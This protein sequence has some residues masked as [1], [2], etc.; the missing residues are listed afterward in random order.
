MTPEN[1]R[2]L[3]DRLSAYLDDELSDAERAEVEMYLASSEDARR[4]LAELRRTTELLRSLPRGKAPAD[5][6]ELLTAQ[7]E[8]NELLGDISAPPS[9][10]RSPVPNLGRWL[11]SAA[12]I[13]LTVSAGYLTYSYLQKDATTSPSPTGPMAAREERSRTEPP[14]AERRERSRTAARPVE[15]EAKQAE[16][17]RS[18]ESE[19]ARGV[20]ARTKV[21]TEAPAGRPPATEKGSIS[22]VTRIEDRVTLREQ[23]A[24]APALARAGGYGGYAGGPQPAAAKAAAHDAPADIGIKG[25]LRS[26]P[27]DVEIRLVYTDAVSREAAAAR[28]SAIL[29]S[30]ESDDVKKNAE[31]WSLAGQR[32][33]D[34]GH[35]LNA[36][37]DHSPG[38]LGKERQGSETHFAFAGSAE[39]V[40]S[41]FAQIQREV[42]KPAGMTVSADGYVTFGESGTAGVGDDE[43]FR[44]QSVPPSPLARPGDIS[45]L[46]QADAVEPVPSMRTRERAG[47]AEAELRASA[48]QPARPAS[49]RRVDAGEA[50]AM[51]EAA[52]TD[53]AKLGCAARAAGVT[54]EYETEEAAMQTPE[55]RPA[56]SAPAGRSQPRRAVPV[57][58]EGT[59]TSERATS[60]PAPEDEG[61]LMADQVGQA[62]TTR[63][64]E[65]MGQPSPPAVPAPIRVRLRLVGPSPPRANQPMGPTQV[66]AQDSQPA[67]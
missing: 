47:G 50:P 57:P 33:R 26:R 17:D 61:Q 36:A 67:P 43:T 60:R 22:E 64:W 55:T 56:A 66:P 46:R 31:A 11:A 13:A 2:N 19:L 25:A 3:D 39:M 30:Y 12:A 10:V 53:H 59:A 38:R 54:Y 20:A 63:E 65:S 62:V 40:E 29:D 41:V 6:V 16:A 5:M 24:S 45:A 23:P 48:T 27:R 34:D 42:P 44:Y 51:V 37:M 28:I 9:R 52:R 32:L 21:A 15:P 8:R 49:P 1:A 4:T 14:G 7:M 18:A 58:A 35:N